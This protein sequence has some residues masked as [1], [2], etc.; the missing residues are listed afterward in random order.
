L[1]NIE[2]VSKR[3]GAKIALDGV[4]LHLERGSILGVIGPNGAGKTTLLRTVVGI[5]RPD[6]GTVYL[7]GQDLLKHPELKQHVGYVAE[8]QDYYPNFTVEDMVRFYR[9]T[10][11]NWNEERYKELAAFFELPGRQKTKA[12]SKGMKTQ[13]ALLLNMSIMPKLL[14][15]DE[16]TS[17][18]D[19]IV[20]KKVLKALVDQVAAFGTGVVM[21]SHN[22]SQIERVCDQVA[23]LHQSR[24]LIHGHVHELKN[25][26]R[27]IQ[28]G[29]SGDFPE[30]LKN[31][32]D[33][34]SVEQ[35][36][37]VYILVMRAGDLLTRLKQYNPVILEELDMD[38]EEIFVHQ[39][40]GRRVS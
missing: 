8:F 30:E 34:L 22:L 39:M 21:A 5:I 6:R 29:F 11:A 14:V 40:E 15:L 7:D 3:Y 25:R 20:R 10:Y 13:L 38:I 18:L 27:K 24:I 35:V 33:L 23:V 28:V 17:G 9:M 36:G 26:I 31:H 16:P 4:N 12:L 32:C 2:N 19:P 1:L 37:R